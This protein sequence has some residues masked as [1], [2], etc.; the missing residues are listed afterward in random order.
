MMKILLNYLKLNSAFKIM[1]FS[2]IVITACDKD[3]EEPGLM[4]PEETGNEKSFNMILTS[5]Q[6]PGGTI[7]FI[8][9]DDGTTKVEI[10]LSGLSG[11]GSHPAH[12]HDNSGAEGGGIAISLE[13]VDGS[14]GESEIIVAALDNGTPITYEA[15]IDFDGHVNV[16]LSE[17]DLTTIV[18]QGEIGPNELTL[19]IEV[20][21]LAEIGGSGVSGDIT[22]V[23]RV[24]GEI[25]SIISLENTPAGGEHPAHIHLNSVATGGDVAISL[26]PV[27]GDNGFS[28]TDFD[29]L[30]NG[31]AITFA[32][33]QDFDGHVN[34][35][36]SATDLATVVSSGDIGGN[37]LTG[38]MEEYTL[39]EKAV[40]GISGTAL[41]KERKN[42]K[43]L[44]E[45]ML[46]N[47]P[48]EG[49]HPAHIHMLS[50]AEGGAVVFPLTSVDGLSGMS[51][52]D[53]S[54]DMS[55]NTVT[56]SDLIDYD[57]HINVHL[58]AEG[59][60]TIVAQGD[61]GG[62]KLTG[63]SMGYELKEVAVA[64]ISGTVTYFERK[65]GN[66]L[67]TISLANTPEGGVHP[68][69][70][71]RNSALEG[72]EIFVALNPVDGTTGMSMT[73]PREDESGLFQEL[74]YEFLII[75][76]G[77]INVH[78]S[79]EDLGTIVAQGDVGSN[80]LTGNSEAYQLDELNGSG[81]SG[82]ITFE[83][84]MSGETLAT[85]MLTGTPDDGDHPSHIHDGSVENPGGI[86]ISLNNVDGSTGK[87]MTHIEKNDAGD[88]VSYNDLASF[89]G[90]VKVHL[91][92]MALAT[93]VAAG[94]IGGNSGARVSFASDVKPLLDAN[95]Q[96]SGCH[97]S[98][99]G[100]PSFETYDNISA[101]AAKIKNRTGNGTMP[102]SSSDKSLTTEQ[103]QLIADWVDDG[104]M[105]N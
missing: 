44:V 10:K 94:D 13:N 14:T 39:G 81:V 52:T 62:N 32:E 1:L 93:V 82:T 19:N 78:L 11:S 3:D 71:H 77:H 6:L 58:S 76:D 20:Y 89:N 69:H 5:T 49:V 66:A 97:G 84:R 80:K 95:C 26:N 35:H 57:G 12:I 7:K 99:G 90:H 54:K 8:E 59:L 91:S 101:N 51:Y 23:E 92:P 86:V 53:V 43:T 34:V 79:A 70:I 27:N 96:V 61:I 40:A 17:S 50:A 18:A 64:G 15:L 16:H 98:N 33:L 88:D 30:N 28:L 45:I 47:T 100:I 87:S 21:D 31:T 103:V 55:D 22:F 63:E 60:S 105:N 37:K 38:E 104:A 68:A 75:D 48:A 46:Q 41:F 102:P 74:P 25:L 2:L 65:N 67:V 24:S 4:P 9:L 72:G 73:T 83:E 56:Y 36:L 42:G 29:Q 85:I